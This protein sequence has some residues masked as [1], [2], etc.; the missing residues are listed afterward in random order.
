MPIPDLATPIQTASRAGQIVRHLQGLITTGHLQAGQRLPTERELASQF[1]VSVP[2][3]NKAMATLESG[4]YVVRKVGAGTSVAT[5]VVIGDICMSFH[6]DLVERGPLVY[7]A[8]LR[9][10]ADRITSAGFRPEVILTSVA[11]VDQVREVDR[12]HLFRALA[13]GRIAGVITQGWSDELIASAIARGIAVTTISASA[14]G[15]GGFHFA[16]DEMI[17]RAIDHLVSRG[18]RRIALLTHE[19]PTDQA[20]HV[21]LFNAALQRHGL[22]AGPLLLQLGDH[23]STVQAVNGALDASDPPTAML[24]ADENL[25]PAVTLATSL[26]GIRISA[27]LALVSHATFGV[28]SAGTQSFTRCGFDID[29]LATCLVE[30]IIATLRGEPV[31]SSSTPIPARLVVGSST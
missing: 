28:E 16:Y 9:R 29:E 31:P 10:L 23:L 26:R 8:L 20:Q 12:S 5:N 14:Q 3:V 4:G 2:T 18:H 17:D 24:I 30:R 15:I 1:G 7:R 6:A 27:D 13:D 25:L 11:V 21:P 22:A 19:S